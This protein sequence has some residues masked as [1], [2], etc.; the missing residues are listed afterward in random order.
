[1][2][3]PGAAAWLWLALAAG[4]AAAAARRSLA[5]WGGLGAGRPS[6][7]ICV[8]IP[9]NMS[10]CHGIGYL[11]MRL[12]NLLEHDTMAE[13]SQQAASWLPLLNVRCHPDTQLFL[14]SLFSPVCLDRAIYPCRSLCDKVRV[15]CEARMNAY[16]FPWPD[17]F[18]C[19]RFPVDNDMCITPQA[20]DDAAADSGCIVCNQVETYENILDNFCRADF[21]VRTKIRRLRKTKLICKKAKILKGPNEL[22]KQLRRPVLLLQAAESCCEEKARNT[23]DAFLIMGHSRDKKLVPS[24]IMP[25]EKR[26]RPLK[27]AVRMFK[28]LNCSDPKFL[29]G[30]GDNFVNTSIVTPVPKKKKLR[31]SRTNPH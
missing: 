31:Q 1:M 28:K 24:F 15:G 16:G 10:L 19:D 5:Y 12:P 18:R 26:S 17:M 6:Q 2:T 30:I 20:R 14:C 4:A 8:D 21:A 29:T 23:R 22:S 11:K 7:P 27:T 13:V 9:R 3:G 25:W